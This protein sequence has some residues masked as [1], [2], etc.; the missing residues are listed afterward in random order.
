MFKNK[1]KKR[2][3][4]ITEQPQKGIAM[5]IAI[6]LLLVLGLLGGGMMMVTTTD[7]NIAAN[8][9]RDTQALFI[10]ESGIQEALQRFDNDIAV[11]DPAISPNWVAA[12]RESGTEETVNDTDFCNTKQTG[13]ILKY[14]KNSD[15]VTITY[16]RDKSGNIL[17]YNVETRDTTT[18][19]TE[20]PIYVI[21][22]SGMKGNAKRTVEIE[23]V[24]RAFNLKI[25]AGASCG[26]GA[27]FTGNANV[28]GFNHFHVNQDSTP[29]NAKPDPK[30]GDVDCAD[31]HIDTTSSYNYPPVKAQNGSGSGHVQFDGDPA[32]PE[33]DEN[34]T[35]LEPHQYLGITSRKW[36]EILANP[37]NS[38][39]DNDPL[40]G[41]TYINGDGAIAAAQFKTGE[42]ILYVNGDL[43]WSSGAKYR[44]FI[45]VEGKLKIT[46][47]PWILGGMVI[48][49]ETDINSF[50]SGNATI[51]LSRKAIT[52][53]LEDIIEEYYTFLAWREK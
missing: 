50:G 49:G 35:V 22:S 1:D 2:L 42:G 13:T 3:S 8:Q 9:Q 24:K 36:Q 39:L 18:F 51:L 5:V 44:G 30:G 16:K 32:E 26:G 46:G 12:I 37:D 4:D 38:S 21:T 29:D 27:D 11:G 52:N 28:C 10:A 45:Y 20:S 40:I 48:K 6:M 23:Y 14:C 15:P 41:F 31:F 47:S 33:F 53:Q 43:S 25:D 19:P 17:Y 7:V 34:Y